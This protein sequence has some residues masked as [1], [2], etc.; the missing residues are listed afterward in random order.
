MALTKSHVAGP[1][2][3]AVREMTFGDLLRQ[4]A[5]AAPD[6]LALIAGVADPALRRQWTYAQFYHQA[7][8]TARA[9]LTRFKPGERIAVWAQNIPEWV[10][11]Q[12]GA[13]MAGM[14]LVT[15]N[16]AFRAREVEYVLK[17]SR[18]AGVFAVSG[19]RGN[20]MLET[21]HAVAPN[22]A[23]LRE[24]ICFD[25]WNAF[26]A[27]GDDPNIKLPSVNPGD[28]VMIQYTSGTTG[29][30]KGALLC[31]RGLLN[32][33]ADTAERMGVDP[34]DIFVTT[35]PLF[36]TGGCVCCVLGSVSK[37]ATQVLIEAF[38]PA[39]VLE[40]FATYRGNAMVGVPTMLI[41]MLEHPT[42]P[43]TDLS[44]VKAICSGGSTVPA[45]LVKRLEEKLGAPFTIVFGQT[46]CSPVAAQ[47]RTDDSVE[48]KAGTIGLPLPNMETRIIDPSTGETV[49]IGTIGEFC[50]RGYHVMLGYFE[51]PEATRAAIDADGWLHTGDLC[52][53]DARGYCTVEGRLKDMIIRGGENIY[54]RE[55]EELLF[56]HPKVGEVAVIGV[57]HEKWGEEVAAF[58]RPVSGAV[59][60]KDELTDYMRSRLAPHKTPKHWI[61]VEAF[62]LTGSGKIQKFK[63]RDA[64]TK[65]EATAI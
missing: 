61:V 55:L 5:E 12:F 47:T 3:P 2:R 39:I 57:P 60:D 56:Q 46:E 24:I 52:A 37:A 4:A 32:N 48:D 27:A 13:G 18:A 23:E 41:A 53:M 20:P 22:C 30:P 38:D 14:V 15:V 1:S 16:P 58:I 11:L 59:I 42:F 26:I 44:S 10:M 33:G 50:T 65:G 17:Q 9:L 45:P 63:L 62:P 8:R 31:H 54:P 43:T 7:Q 25:D 40:M 19:F 36:H 29:F 35:M 64:W 34:G 6:R 28:P 49:P 51:M 21:V